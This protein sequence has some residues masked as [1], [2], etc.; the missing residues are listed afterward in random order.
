M[1]VGDSKHPVQWLIYDSLDP[2]VVQKEVWLCFQEILSASRSFPQGEVRQNFIHD[3]SIRHFA[4]AL[5]NRSNKFKCANVSVSEKTAFLAYPRRRPLQWNMERLVR[6]EKMRAIFAAAAVE[7]SNR[8]ARR[9]YLSAITASLS[10]QTSTRPRCQPSGPKE[11]NEST[12]DT[13]I[14]FSISTSA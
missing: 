14:H 10:A 4:P 3:F 11:G 5:G 13:L 12:S 9:Q 7:I 6:R 2:P 1:L 8:T